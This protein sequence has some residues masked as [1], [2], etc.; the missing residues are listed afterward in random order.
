MPK[1]QTKRVPRRPKRPKK[2]AS[3]KGTNP[4]NKGMM[5]GPQL[6][7][8]IERNPGSLTTRILNK[9]RQNKPT[10][11]LNIDDFQ[12]AKNAMGLKR[13]GKVKKK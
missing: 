3:L 8:F 6:R 2:P 4:K 9:A 1:T 10:G 7:D 5:L 11:R 12:N 13:G